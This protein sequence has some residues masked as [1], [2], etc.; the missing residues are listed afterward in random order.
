MSWGI[1]NAFVVAG[2]LGIACAVLSVIVV[3]RKWA[4]IGEGIGHSGFGGA[5]TAW[6]AALIFPSLDQP[7]AP[8]A[9]VIVFCIVAA[10]AMGKLSRGNVVHADAAI[11][12]FLVASLAWG[13]VAQHIYTQVRRAEPAG[14]ATF[15]FGQ[16]KSLSTVYTTS[17]VFVCLAVLVTTILLWKEI[18]AY[19]FD[20]LMAETS[21]V[22]AGFIHYVLMLLLAMLIVIGVRVAGSV[23][24]TALLVLPG[25]TALL[26]WRR[27]AGVMTI[28][29][30]SA[31]IGTTVGVALGSFWRFIP[32]GPAI[33][34]VMFAEFLLAYGFAR[35]VV[36][37]AS[38]S[39]TLSR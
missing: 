33:V 12:I 13:F 15:L 32:A 4:F 31:I 24:V 38:F 34:L 39:K 2:A 25:A 19:S 6:L 14:F 22:R 37:Y 30:L 8:Y 1:A 9:A 36:P 17:A 35:L 28:A 23:L 26:L 21:G 18:V 7:W 29:V 10:L 11:G 27:M 3:L 5:G 16:M 20:P